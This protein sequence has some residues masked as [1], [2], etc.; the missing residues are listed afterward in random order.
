MYL[1]T[2]A[3]NVLANV[4]KYTPL[5]STLAKEYTNSMNALL[6]SIA[7]AKPLTGPMTSRAALMAGAYFSFLMA[8]SF[9]TVATAPVF[10]RATPFGRWMKGFDWAGAITKAWI[11]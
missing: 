11:D 5:L 1:D 3:I 8:I 9:S 4:S 7:F 2:F 6:I 10:G